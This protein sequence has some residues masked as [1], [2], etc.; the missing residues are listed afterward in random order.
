MQKA[1]FVVGF[2]RDEGGRDR[3]GTTRRRFREGE[4]DALQGTLTQN[5]GCRTNPPTMT[6]GEKNRAY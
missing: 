5:P 4:S 1:A 6:V 2:E 3:S